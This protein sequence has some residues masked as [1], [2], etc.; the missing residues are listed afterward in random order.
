MVWMAVNKKPWDGFLAFCCFFW[1]NQ[2][3]RIRLLGLS[4]LEMMNTDY[5]IIAA[6]S[7]NLFGLSDWRSTLLYIPLTKLE[8]YFY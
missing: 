3:G 4:V 5:G 8:D 6:I 2:T 1:T 7:M